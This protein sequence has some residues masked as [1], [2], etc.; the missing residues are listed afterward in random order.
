MPFFPDVNVCC[1]HDGKDGEIDGKIT[2]FKDNTL[3]KCRQILTVRKEQKL[4]YANITLPKSVSS[5]KGF[6]IECYRK[7]IALSKAQQDKIV[8]IIEEGKEAEE[9][10]VT[11]VTRSD[12]A[13][14]ISNKRT[15]VFLAFCLFCGKSRKKHNGIE[16]P[17]IN[18]ETANFEENIRRYVEAKLDEEMLIKISSSNF[19]S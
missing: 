4:K 14:S 9:R 11:R 5:H 15:G 12:L 18:V 19:Y 6:H 7:F 2:V 10:K 17:L 1:L 8:A 3:G 16:Q 13:S